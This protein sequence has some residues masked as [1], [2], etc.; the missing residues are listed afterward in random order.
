M[1]SPTVMRRAQI[2]FT[3]IEL[4]MV[5]VI[6]GILAAIGA[7]S[8]RD[9]IIKARVR[10]VSSDVYASLVFTRSEA[11]KR[12]ATVRLQPICATSTATAPVVPPTVSPCAATDWVNGWT[13]VA[14]GG[15]ILEAKDPPAIVAWAA[16][17]S[18]AFS[19]NGRAIGTTDIVFTVRST[20][21]PSV[22]MRCITISPSGRPN[23]KTDTNGNF[24]DGCN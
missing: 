9:M 12:N 1:L 23:I 14:T 7:P 10:T 6:V 4:M 3:I 5:M 20:E 16:P 8:L 2:G 13:V 18:I 19:G 24:A 15:T 21:Y 17:A 11:I 22:P